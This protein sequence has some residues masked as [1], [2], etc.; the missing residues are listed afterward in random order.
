M[1]VRCISSGHV[2]FASYEQTL[3]RTPLRLPSGLTLFS[4]GLDMPRTIRKIL[5]TEDMEQ[6]RERLDMLQVS[7]DE[8]RVCI[9]REYGKIKIADL[10]TGKTTEIGVED[11]ALKVTIL[12]WRSKDEL[13]FAVVEGLESGVS[14]RA[15]IVL[16]SPAGTRCISKDWPESVAKDFLDR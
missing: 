5:T 12:V 10:A 8:T 14:H 3:P 2:L 11:A 9:P 16:W 6:T 13:C 15:K 4:L 1:P 7:P